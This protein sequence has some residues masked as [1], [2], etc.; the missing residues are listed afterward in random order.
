F[1]LVVLETAHVLGTS[2]IPGLR[3]W[4]SGL[5]T[6]TNVPVVGEEGGNGAGN[7]PNTYWL[8][9]GPSGKV[10]F[11]G[12]SNTGNPRDNYKDVATSASATNPTVVIGGNTYYTFQDSNNAFFENSRRYIPSRADALMFHDAYG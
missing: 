10:L 12:S 7:L 9:N 1:T 4:T 8:F 2:K 3:I 6:N 5:M 11:N